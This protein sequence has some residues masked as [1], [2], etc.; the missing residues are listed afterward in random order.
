M[1]SCPALLYVQSGINFLTMRLHFWPDS[2]WEHS[3]VKLEKL[4]EFSLLNRHI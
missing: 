2:P 3:C 4:I 1:C